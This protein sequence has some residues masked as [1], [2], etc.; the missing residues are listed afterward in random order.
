MANLQ[1]TDES[2]TDV[3]EKEIKTVIAQETTI[4][5]LTK[6]LKKASNILNINLG[7]TIHKSAV[8]SSIG[9]N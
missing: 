8:S 2:M 7:S 4:S 6:S 5:S 1:N 3:K 9:A